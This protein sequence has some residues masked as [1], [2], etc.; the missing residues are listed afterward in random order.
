MEQR[1]Y[2]TPLREPPAAANTK[3]WRLRRQFLSPEKK[4]GGGSFS[5]DSAEREGWRDGAAGNQTSTMTMVPTARAAS[6]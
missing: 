1:A 4:G 5:F 3:K 6:T 2:K